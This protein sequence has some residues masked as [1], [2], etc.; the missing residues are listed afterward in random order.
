MSYVMWEKELNEVAD[1]RGRLKL[2]ADMADASRELTLTGE[3]LGCFMR[4]LAEDLDGALGII[5]ERGNKAHKAHVRPYTLAQIIGAISGQQPILG[6]DLNKIT[7]QLREFA[8]INEDMLWARDAWEK[9]VTA[10]GGPAITTLEDFYIQYHP[11]KAD[12]VM[13]EEV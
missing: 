6:R 12:N 7:Y 4:R 2:F 3:D 1:V 11:V 8:D 9:F 13:Q 5:E 10:A